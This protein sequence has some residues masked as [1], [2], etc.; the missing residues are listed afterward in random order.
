MAENGGLELLAKNLM[1][2]KKNVWD[3][4]GPEDREELI[5]LGEEY[6]GL[7]KSK[8]ERKWWL[9]FQIWHQETVF[10]LD[11]LMSRVAKAGTGSSRLSGIRLLLCIIGYQGLA[12]GLK[13]AGSHI[14]APRL[15]LKPIP[16]MRKE[17]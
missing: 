6:N 12:S 5:M 11:H 10:C 13:I 4:M 1:L 14:D 17:N 16:Y 15:D 2:E 7:D 3:E 8:T 9:F